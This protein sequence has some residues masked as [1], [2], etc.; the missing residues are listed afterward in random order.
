MPGRVVAAYDRRPAAELAEAIAA[1]GA[2]PV[3]L[4]L[5]VDEV[6]ARPRCSS[7]PTCSSPAHRSRPRFPTTDPWLRE[8]LS[9]RRGAGRGDRQRGRPLPAADRARVLAGVTGT[10]GKTTTDGARWRRCCE[11]RACRRSL[12]G[13]IGTPLV[14]RSLELGPDDWAVLE[15]S[16]LQLPTISRGADVAL[17]TNIGEDHLDRHGTRR[18]LPGGQGAARRA[19]RAADGPG[20]PQ[21]DDPGCRELGERLPPDERW[22]GTGWH[23]PGRG[24]GWR[25]WSRSG[26]L[27]LDGERLVCRRRRARCPDGTCCA[28]VLGAA[29]A[30]QP[31]RRRRLRDRA[32]RRATFA[33][34][35]H[36][37][38]TVAERDGVRWVNDSQATIPHGGD[39]RASRPSMPRSCS[40]PAART[41]G[42]STAHSPMPIAARCRARGPDRRDRRRARG[43]SS[44]DRVPVQRARRRWT[45][46]WRSS[47]EHGAAG[48]RRAAGAGRGLAS[49]C[50]STTPRAATRSASAVEPDRR[51]ADDAP[52]RS[53]GAATA[54]AARSR[55]RGVRRERHEPA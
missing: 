4:A 6:D 38:E 31:G 34:V 45:R 53:P 12:G 43:R 18:G 3:R 7:T 33:G 5:G 30:A 23:R 24:G 51:R 37:L 1:L 27:T 2:R 21:P 52:P 16:E 25:P 44:R 55:G 28:N 48:R 14:E 49:T 42:S 36:R 8:A 41:R 15:L 9:A 20:R 11:A 32:S 40:S 35:P 54:R 17:Y 19:D 47:R 26:W 50:S 46:R 29:L 22:P 13:N 10:K 39:R